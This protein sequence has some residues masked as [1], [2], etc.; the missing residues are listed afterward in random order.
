MHGGNKHDKTDE[1][2]KGTNRWMNA[3]KRGCRKLKGW[4]WALEKPG[5]LGPQGRMGR[6]VRPG[7]FERRNGS[8]QEEY[9]KTVDPFSFISQHLSLSSLPL[10]QKRSVLSPLY[11]HLLRLGEWVVG[12]FRCG[13]WRVNAAAP[14]RRS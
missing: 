1:K 11:L 3:R 7:R 5:A 6:W 13:G 12:K 8:V 14:P 2:R 4:S 10:E 9:I